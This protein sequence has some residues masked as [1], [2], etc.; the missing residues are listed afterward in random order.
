MLETIK[1]KLLKLLL[2]NI[3]KYD[4]SECREK[5]METTIDDIKFLIE[6]QERW[7]STC[8]LKI[9]SKQNTYFTQTK[10]DKYQII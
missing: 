4:E 8:Q 6:E 3:F 9:T 5:W 1:I 10:F 7:S 2:N